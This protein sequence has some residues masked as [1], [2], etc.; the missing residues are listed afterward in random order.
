M[1]C[2]KCGKVANIAILQP[3]GSF[4]ESNAFCCWCFAQDFRDK[5]LSSINNGNGNGSDEKRRN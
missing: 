1:K 3:D 5:L 2:S 4:F